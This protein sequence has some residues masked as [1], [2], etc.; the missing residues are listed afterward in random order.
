MKSN[1][2]SKSPLSIAIK[3]ALVGSSAALALMATAP[4]QADEVDEMKQEVQLLMERIDQLELKQ[5]QAATTWEQIKQKDEPARVIRNTNLQDYTPEGVEPLSFKLGSSDTKV[6]VSGYI[7][8]DA[9]FDADQDVGDSFIFSSI[10]AD[11]TAGAERNPAVRLHAK[12]SRLRV[13]S[14]TNVNGTQL[15][16]LL[17]GDFLGQGGNQTFSNSTT[18]RIRHAWITYGNWGFGQYWSNFMENDFVAY[19]G[20]VD[21][22]GPV[23]QAFIRAPQIRYTADNGF[24]FSIE[25]PETT[26]SG[27][28]GSLRESTG[29][30][31]SDQAPDI[32]IAWR[33]GPGGAGGSY[34]FAAVSRQLG[35][36]ADTNADGILDIDETENGTGIML[37]GGW[38]LGSAYL[39]AH[40]NAG[41]GIGRY[42]INGFQ[43]DLFVDGAGNVET[44]ESSGGNVGVT[45]DVGDNDKINITY[46]FF[47]NDIPTRSNGID[48][49]TSIHV[50][51]INNMKGGLSIGAEVINGEADY[52]DGSTGENTRFQFMAK[53]S[54]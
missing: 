50:G 31:G 28:L 10:A 14:S 44:V 45:F 53:K 12:Q 4:V 1:I 18:F 29:G 13:K 48:E 17:E 27:L 24:S 3:T 21:F 32:T 34:E 37:A 15:N 9:I 11:G 49:L 6:T 5:E 7:K 51:Y 52:A 35:V 40:Y 47:E 54:F 39:Y 16:T 23:G 36:Q 42:I 43:N 33:G 20:T 46:G 41:D 25:N 38:Q 26:G 2:F 30:A 8:L 22:F 19:P